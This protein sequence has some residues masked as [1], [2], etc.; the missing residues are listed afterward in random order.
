MTQEDT[1]M[2][3]LYKNLK[4][5]KTTWYVYVPQCWWVWKK[6]TASTVSDHNAEGCCLFTACI[7][8]SYDDAWM[9]DFVIAVQNLKLINDEDM[10][11][12]IDLKS[13]FAKKIENIIINENLIWFYEINRICYPK[14]I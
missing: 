14:L 3:S 7:N 1:N 5:H 11:L 12:S 9:K 4:P 2:D 6:I 10:L 8:R 13:F